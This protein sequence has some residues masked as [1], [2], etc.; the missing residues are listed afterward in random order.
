VSLVRRISIMSVSA[1]QQITDW[2]EKLALGQYTQCF[3]E[4]EIDFSILG[5]LTDRDLEKISVAPL[6]HRR[7]LLRA[8]AELSSVEKGTPAVAAEGAAPVAPHPRDA[9]ERRQCA[10]ATLAARVEK[11]RSRPVGDLVLRGR[12]EALRA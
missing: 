2:L 10:S 12:V 11:F 4:N 5:D 6:G 8:I 9:V 1:A 3:A 7:K